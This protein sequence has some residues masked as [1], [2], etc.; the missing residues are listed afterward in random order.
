MCK[1]YTECSCLTPKIGF[2]QL[3]CDKTE[4]GPGTNS[5]QFWVKNVIAKG[6]ALKQYAE[7]ISQF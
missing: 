7:G 5:Q 6:K 3:A 1:I 2:K 4:I